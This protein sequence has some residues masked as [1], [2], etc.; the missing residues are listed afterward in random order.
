MYMEKNANDKCPFNAVPAKSWERKN[1]FNVMGRDKTM[2]PE[3]NGPDK[4]GKMK[5]WTFKLF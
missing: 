4:F 2:K 5:P 1:S 3:C